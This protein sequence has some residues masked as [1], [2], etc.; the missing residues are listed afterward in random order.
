MAQIKALS[1]SLRLTLSLGET[2][3]KAV[4][5]TVSLSKIGTQATAEQL[6]EVAAAF[7]ELLA[8]PVAAVK[9]YDTG[10]LEAE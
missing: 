4:T 2:D 9:K 10:M 8:Y 3:G 7:G 1:T 6:G 5:K